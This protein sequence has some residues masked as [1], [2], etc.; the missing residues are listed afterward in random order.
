MRHAPHAHAHPDAALASTS[1]STFLFF[2]SLLCVLQLPSPLFSFFF[3]FLMIRRPPSSPLFP[4]T[5]L[6]RSSACRP[7]GSGSPSC[8]RDQRGAG[9]RARRRPRCA[10]GKRLRSR[11]PRA[12]RRGAS[13][14]PAARARSQPH[15]LAAPAREPH[16]VLDRRNRLLVAVGREHAPAQV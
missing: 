16:D 14:P 12:R 15:H 11:G 8:R 1:S 7:G 2:Y 10:R 13:L 3:F 6:F 9:G 5:P 4:Y